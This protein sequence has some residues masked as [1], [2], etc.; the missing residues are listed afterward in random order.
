MRAICKVRN[1]P[2]RQW[3]GSVPRLQET[4]T[5]ELIFSRYILGYISYKKSSIRIV[6]APIMDRVG[7]V[8]GS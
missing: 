1:G 6:L 2:Q 5:K 4:K 8:E 7:T 3:P